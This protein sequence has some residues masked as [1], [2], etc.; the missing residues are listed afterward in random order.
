MQSSLLTARQ[1]VAILTPFVLASLM[2]FPLGLIPPGTERPMWL[3]AAALLMLALVAG[4]GVVIARG[5]SQRW[6]SWI[7]IGYLGVV[8]LAR[9]AESGGQSGLAALVLIPLIGIA[10]YGTTL[11]LYACIVGIA[12]TLTMPI[13]AGSSAEYAAGPE[14]RRTVAILVVAL[15][16]GPTVQRLVQRARESELKYRTVFDNVREVVFQ[17][18][19]DGRWT[20]L[21][22]AWRDMTGYEIEASLGRPFVD[23]VHPEDRSGNERK[24]L[25]LRDREIDSYRYEMRYRVASGD[26][27][28]FEVLARRTVTPQGEPGGISGTMSDITD[29]F[30]AERVKE[31]FFALVS[32]ELRTPL[33]A[34]IGYLELL[35]Q[36]EGERLPDDGRNFV[37]VMQRNSQRLMR[38][39]G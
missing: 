14:L 9:H 32:H 31:E 19:D 27:L 26:Y 23:F 2:P 34:I 13:L 5:G 30:E 4:F 35:D 21:N 15:L 11:D 39:I 1:R 12:L 24:F 10:L 3:L 37:A 18:D 6:I 7:S 16:T 25:Q 33:A 28:W 22:S 36:E 17:T 20:L 8:G 38:L 29:R